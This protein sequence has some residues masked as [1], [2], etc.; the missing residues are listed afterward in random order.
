MLGVGYREKACHTMSD[1]KHEV[2]RRAREEEALPVVPMKIVRCIMAELLKDNVEAERRRAALNDRSQ[3]P[4]SSRRDIPDFES[5]LQCFSS[6]TAVVCHTHPHKACELWAYQALMISEHRKCCRRGWLLYDSAFCQQII[7]LKTV[8]FSRVNQC[9]YS[10]TFLAYG[11]RG[12][13]CT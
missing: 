7:S 5:W 9:L 10:T 1:R 13:F 2:S 11:G 4:W 6:Y 8:D 12:Q 3:V